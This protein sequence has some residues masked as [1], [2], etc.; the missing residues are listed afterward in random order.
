MSVTHRGLSSTALAEIIADSLEPTFRLLAFSSFVAM[1]GV[2][3][4]SDAL[5]HEEAM[6]KTIVKSLINAIAAA[7]SSAQ[8]VAGDTPG[9]PEWDALR[10]ATFDEVY[11]LATQRIEAIFQSIIEEV[12]SQQS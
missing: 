1:R 3:T 7:V 10:Y 5:E 11:V 9:T 4:K 6:E 8:M 2:E 12:G